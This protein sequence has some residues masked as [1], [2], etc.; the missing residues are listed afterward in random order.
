VGSIG[1]KR[2]GIWSVAFLMTSVCS[3]AATRNAGAADNTPEAAPFR[4]QVPHNEVA[5]A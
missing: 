2:G 4:V 1:R 5:Q 3:V